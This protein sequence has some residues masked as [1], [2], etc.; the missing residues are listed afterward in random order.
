MSPR[1]M[2]TVRDLRPKRGPG[3]IILFGRMSW[4]VLRWR[5]IG[6]QL[7]CRAAPPRPALAPQMP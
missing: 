4:K 7:R 1:A 2:R 3:N 5:L 6:D